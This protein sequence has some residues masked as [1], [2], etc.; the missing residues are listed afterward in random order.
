[1]THS[2]LFI[3]NY[4]KVTPGSQIVVPEHPEVNKLSTGELVSIGSVIAS[5]ALLIVTAFK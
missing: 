2:F 1:V 4:P 3:R 5:L